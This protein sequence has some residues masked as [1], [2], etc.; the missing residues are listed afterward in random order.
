MVRLGEAEENGGGA[1]TFDLLLNEV[2]WMG[3]HCYCTV[4]RRG[5][6]NWKERREEK[7]KGRENE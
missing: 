4:R 6:L 5:A 2:G 3:G 1:I 7:E